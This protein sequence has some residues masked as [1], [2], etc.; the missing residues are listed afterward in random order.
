MKELNKDKQN[1]TSRVE[2]YL[3]KQSKLDTLRFISCGS[4]DDG[5]STLIGRMLYEAQLLFEDQHDQFI[6]GQGSETEQLA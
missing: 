5:K 4:V 2:E 6:A 3:H 1:I